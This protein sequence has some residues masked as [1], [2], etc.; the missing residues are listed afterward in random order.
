MVTT[1]RSPTAEPLDAEAALGTFEAA[2]SS[3]CAPVRVRPVEGVAFHGRLR[4]A[5]ADGLL[6]TALRTSP[7]TVSRTGRLLS[8]TDPEFLKLIWQRSGVSRLSQ[9]GRRGEARPGDLVAYETT[10]PYHL[11]SAGTNWEAVVVAVPRDRLHPHLR[12]FSERTAVPVP[13]TSSPARALSSMLEEL[14]RCE[15]AGSGD[16]PA[17]CHLG[18]ALVSMVLAVYAGLPQVPGGSGPTLADRVRTYALAHLGDPDLGVESIAV[19]LGVS[20]R[21]VHKMCAQEGFTTAAWIRRRRLERIRRDLLDPTLAGRST[22]SIAARWGILDVT[23]LARQ[24]RTA[25][26][27]SPAQLRRQSTAA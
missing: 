20:V 19:A 13:A 12:P 7:N 16:S 18:D 11:D 14:S 10:R 24:F 23:H 25:F 27:E 9:D 3:A 5:T 6:V 26:G 17:A 1:P 2:V 8:S 21:Q 4:S 15:D 22:P